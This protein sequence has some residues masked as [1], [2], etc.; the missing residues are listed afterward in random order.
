MGGRGGFS[1]PGLA[2]AVRYVLEVKAGKNTGNT[3]RKALEN[4]KSE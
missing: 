2:S 1:C 4:G 3:A